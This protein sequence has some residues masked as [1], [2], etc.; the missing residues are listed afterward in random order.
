[1]SNNAK[2]KEI[3][4]TLKEP[5]WL[6]AWREKQLGLALELPKSIKHGIGISALFPETEQDFAGVAEYH[7][8]AS[9]GIEIY[10][11]SEAVTQEEVEPILKGLMESSFFP[12]PKDF[13]RAMGNALF[14]SGLVVYVQPNLADDGTFI[15]EKLT[16]DTM[17][18]KGSSS[19][20]I[21]VIVKEGAKCELVSNISSGDA[22]SVHSRTLVVLSEQDS[23]IR[24]TQ[25]DNAATGAMVMH[26]SRGVAAGN[27]QVVWRELLAADMLVSSITHNLLIGAGATV[28]VLQGLVARDHAAFDVDVSAEHLAD[29][30]HSQIL[31]AGTG[32]DVS[33][34]LYR[35]LVSMKEGVRKVEGAQEAKFLVLNAG[36][37]V[38]A[39]PSLDI[40]S[41]DVSCAHKLSISHVREGDMFY[42]KLRGLSDEES[43]ALFLEGH[44]AHVFSG[45]ENA[46]IMKAISDIKYATR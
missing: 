22:G 42:P 28:K 5:E 37:K 6:L 15:T 41:N 36:A 9:K 13:F 46:D 31:T 1:L 44:F 29:D 33:K 3:S 12:A 20:V 25:Q 24:I 19:D 4:Q 39:I 14:A 21:V 26:A 45:E 32:R 43:R 17:V 38:D 7:V 8:D 35:G 30:T 18:S 2:I 11:W 23:R 16:L 10:T 27:A 40:A 34:I